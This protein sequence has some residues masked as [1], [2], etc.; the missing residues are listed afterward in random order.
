MLTPRSPNAIL[1][2]RRPGWA[3]PPA[4][5]FLDVLW[6]DA[7]VVAVHKPSGLQVRGAGLARW[8]RVSAT[9]AVPIAGGLETA[10]CTGLA[11]GDS[12]AYWQ[13][14]VACSGRGCGWVG[15]EGLG[16]GGGVGVAAKCRGARRPRPQVLPAGP[17]HERCTL[18]LLRVFHQQHAA[19][20]K[21]EGAGPLRLDR[22][23]VFL[24]PFRPLLSSCVVVWP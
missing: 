15:G 23:A 21:G 24:P 19:R 3:E 12:T 7:D 22:L 5:S 10:A 16:R 14:G 17:V 18:T 4:P 9:L 11:Q 20:L 2:F 8:L 1:E 6:W 13:G